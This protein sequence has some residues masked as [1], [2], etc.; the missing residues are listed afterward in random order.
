MT[1]DDKAKEM[2]EFMKTP[3][4]EEQHRNNDGVEYARLYCYYRKMGC[5]KRDSRIYAKWSYENLVREKCQQ[6]EQL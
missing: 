6:K 5:S 2:H 1:L 3:E 4:A